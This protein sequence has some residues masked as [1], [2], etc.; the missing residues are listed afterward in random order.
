[1]PTVRFQPLIKRARFEAP[2]F[3]P[4]DMVTIGNQILQGAIFPRLDRAQ[5]IY[6]QST[7]PLT[8][9][10]MRWKNRRYGSSLR[11]LRASGR[12]RRG[13]R[14]IEAG[15]RGGQNPYSYVKI[16]FSDPEAAL[17]IALNNRRVRQWGWSENDK[18]FAA[19]LVQ[20]RIGSAVGVTR[21]A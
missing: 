11:D 19:G 2:G 10:Y 1:M 20:A 21:V 6:D 14:V 13:T 17:R 8:E 15:Q 16:G 18:E 5:D 4:T 3:S 7:P 12:T 9:K